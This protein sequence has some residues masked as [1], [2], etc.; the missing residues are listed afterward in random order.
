MKSLQD[1]SSADIHTLSTPPPPHQIS[2][3]L[4]IGQ[5]AELVPAHTEVPQGRET[6]QLR[7]EGLQLIATHILQ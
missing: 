2:I 4:T 7:R 6:A 5:G 1:F 3:L